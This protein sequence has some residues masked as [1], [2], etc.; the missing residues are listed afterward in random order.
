MNVTNIASCSISF[1]AGKGSKSFP[2]HA[3]AADLAG[4]FAHAERH[5]TKKL[6]AHA[7]PHGAAS[8]LA[9]GADASGL[10]AGKV[11][12]E[13]LGEEADMAGAGVRG[14]RSRRAAKPAAL[15]GDL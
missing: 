6:L 3:T 13:M 9:G 8:A 1:I 7:R 2:P 11:P 10:S 5:L 12:D 15:Q 4:H 14:A